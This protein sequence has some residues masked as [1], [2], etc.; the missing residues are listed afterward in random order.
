MKKTL[1]ECLSFIG[2]EEDTKVVV[3]E[4]DYHPSKKMYISAKKS[5]DVY[6]SF[7]DDIVVDAFPYNFGADDN[8]NYCYLRIAAEA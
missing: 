6:E 3:V 1:R 7:L 2:D 4:G 5:K 8:T